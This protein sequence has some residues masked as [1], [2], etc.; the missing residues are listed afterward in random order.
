LD[1]AWL[2]SERL[3]LGDALHRVWHENEVGE[4]AAGAFPEEIV[5][6]VFSDYALPRSR[7]DIEQLLR[8]EWPGVSLGNCEFGCGLDRSLPFRT[9]AL[10]DATSFSTIIKFWAEGATHIVLVQ[11]EWSATGGRDEIAD[12]YA[13]A[14][15]LT[16]GGPPPCHAEMY[17]C[18]DLVAD[19]TLGR[20]AELMAPTTQAQQILWGEFSAAAYEGRL[21]APEECVALKEEFASFTVDTT[22]GPLARWSAP[23]GKHDDRLYG[24]AWAQ[25]SLSDRRARGA[26]SVAYGGQKPVFG[27]GRYLADFTGGVADDD[28]PTP[29]E[30]IAE[31]ARAH[32]EYWGR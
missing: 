14:C 13:H 9:T 21:H 25:S 11:H 27:T 10:G 26:P 8:V 30:K 32:Q 15:E 1:A 2:A 17:Q 7:A 18:G 3:R 19:G 23:A 22:G 20:R 31:K 12:W 24:F 5:E 4:P 29:G 16:M 28:G 6:R